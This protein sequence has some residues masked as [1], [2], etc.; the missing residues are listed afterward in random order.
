LLGRKTAALGFIGF[1]ASKAA[2]P[3]GPDRKIGKLLTD[4]PKLVFSKKQTESKWANAKTVHGNL[5][6]EIKKLKAEKGK[7]MLVYG[8]AGFVSS[9]IKDHLIDEYHLLYDPRSPGQRYP[10]FQTRC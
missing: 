10:N 2:D 4:I 7:N 9:L 1:W 6:A 3:K 8:G 5:A